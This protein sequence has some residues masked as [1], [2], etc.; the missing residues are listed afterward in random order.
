LRIEASPGCRAQL[1]GCGDQDG[2]RVKREVGGRSDEM[3]EDAGEQYG[4]GEHADAG[5]HQHAGDATEELGR[6]PLLK[7]G[8][9]QQVADRDQDERDDQ[10]EGCGEPSADLVRGTRTDERAV[11]AAIE[12]ACSEMLVVDDRDDGGAPIACCR[13]ADRG[14]G[15][16]HFS[17]FAVDPERQGGGLGRRLVGWAEQA[18]ARSFGAREIELDV[19]AQQELLRAWYERLG[20]TATGETRPFPAHPDYAVPVR[21]DLSLVVLTRRLSEA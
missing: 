18:A 2:A 1:N 14:H 20:Y 15:L 7:A 8:H 12:P 4:H 16:A 3:N 21:D 19:L 11:L 17:M 6:R 9:H 5:E 13:I 10:D